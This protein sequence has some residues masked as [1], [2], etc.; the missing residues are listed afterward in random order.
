MQLFT[1]KILATFYGFHKPNH[2]DESK[3]GSGVGF[4][5]DIRGFRVWRF[6]FWCLVLAHGFSGSDTQKLAGLGQVFSF[7]RGSPSKP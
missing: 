7:T 6:Q 5:S 4:G 2:V 1:C 3:D